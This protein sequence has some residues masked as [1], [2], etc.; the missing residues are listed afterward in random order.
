M[1]GKPN[2]LVR[3][4]ICVARGNANPTVRE[5]RH[6]RIM[7]VMPCQALPSRQNVDSQLGDEVSERSELILQT[8]TAAR[9]ECI[10][11]S[12]DARTLSYRELRRRLFRMNPPIPNNPIPN[13]TSVESVSATR[14]VLNEVKELF[15]SS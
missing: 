6:D 11:R 2:G 4:E 10:E 14:F 9:F 1:Q 12:R 3:S 7:P 5:T 15:K 13:R 8:N